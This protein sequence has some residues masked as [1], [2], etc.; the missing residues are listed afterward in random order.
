MQETGNPEAALDIATTLLM[1]ELELN[2]GVVDSNKVKAP[3]IS[4]M[5]QK[6]K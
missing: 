6:P 3:G 2:L 5:F 4:K 1:N